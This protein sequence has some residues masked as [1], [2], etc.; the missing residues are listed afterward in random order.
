[1]RFPRLA[2]LPVL[3]SI[4]LGGLCVCNVVPVYIYFFPRTW[5]HSSPPRT[6]V[7]SSLSNG[8]MSLSN[9]SDNIFVLITFRNVDSLC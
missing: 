8:C 3:N 6:W 5:V 9:I 7:H 4:Y 2:L 1:M